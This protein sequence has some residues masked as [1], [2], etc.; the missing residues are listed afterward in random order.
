MISIRT[1]L[2]ALLA[3]T[4]GLVQLHAGNYSIDASNSEVATTVHA[5][6]RHQF[7]CS[8]TDYQADI[9][10]D[11]TTLRVLK[12]NLDFNFNALD[13][14]IK[15]RDSKMCNWMEIEN[16]PSAH[17]E[18]TAVEPQASTGEF[19]ATGTLRMHG[20]SRP[21]QIPFTITRE[22]EKIRLAGQTEINYMNWGLEKIRMFIFSVKPL[23]QP[24]FKLEGT[25]KNDT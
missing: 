20:R 22:G 15:K 6:P 8:V 14:R 9:E 21:I 18:M 10:I 25:L 3:G 24:Y 23:I 12:A 7:T 2:L 17:F 11:P 5:S 1:I 13:S 16:H 4:L 19:I